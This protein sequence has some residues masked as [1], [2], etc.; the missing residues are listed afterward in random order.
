MPSS[1]NKLK[2]VALIQ[3]SQH[4]GTLCVP[5]GLLSL[6]SSIKPYG[7]EPIIIDFNIQ[8]VRRTPNFFRES[9]EKILSYDPQVL[10]FTVMCNTFP[11]TLL[12]AEECKKMAPDI[13][14]IFGGPEVS[15]EEVAVLETFKQ[16]DIIVRGEGEITLGELLKA[17]GEKKSF[18]DILG[19]SYRGNGE[20]IRNPDRPF[21]MNLDDLPFL[22]FSLLSGVEGYDNWNV[23]A[24][25]GCPF[26]CTFCSTCKMWKRNFR[27]KSPQRLVQELRQ[28]YHLFKKNENSYVHL[29][30]DH[31]LASRKRADEFLSLVARENIVWTCYSRFD[32]LDETLIKKLKQAGCRAIFLGIETGS[33]EMQKKIKKNLPLQKL[34]H[35]FKLLHE[36]EVEATLSFIIGLPDETA[37]QINQT[38]L[39]ALNARLVSPSIFFVNIFLF[40]FKKGSEL[41]DNVKGKFK[42]AKFWDQG[43]SPLITGLPEE[44]DLIENY[45]HIFPSFFYVE[46]K[47]INLK[48]LQKIHFL[49]RF[50]IE[51]FPHATSILLD[52]CSLTPLQ[53]SQRIIHFFE[54]ENKEKAHK[55]AVLLSP[56]DFTAFM[57]FVIREAR[58]QPQLMKALARE[59]YDF[60]C[61][62][63]KLS[64]HLEI[65]PQNDEY[66]LT[67]GISG[68]ILR[69]KK[70]LFD[71]V[72]EYLYWKGSP[73]IEE[74]K[75]RLIEILAIVPI[76]L[77]EQKLSRDLFDDATEGKMASEEKLRKTQKKLRPH[78]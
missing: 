65:E 39:T 4:G 51:F 17:L 37:A 77:E 53:L 18:S 49:F 22:D 26:Q 73:E 69:M 59:L 40:T 67:H 78:L 28:A 1:S 33:P 44:R 57:T 3:P 70:K 30:H 46:N 8:V 45:P 41:Y 6:A 75:K 16:V 74:A 62:G 58:T 72:V 9:A 48:T 34:P 43:M 68:K 54:E 55:L 36:N 20:V 38:L 2:R 35:V 5:V 61:Y 63:R 23:E 56:H 50:L 19:I 14:I 27:M 10:G 13:P 71:E 47:E 52:V 76:P 12:I 15:F 24:G 29:T 21:I 64:D 60:D 7:Y 32:T 66:F 42:R 25:R 11:S 31:F